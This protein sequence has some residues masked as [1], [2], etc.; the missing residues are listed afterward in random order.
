MNRRGTV[1]RQH[2]RVALRAPG[3]GGVAVVGVLHIGLPVDVPRRNLAPAWQ[4][5][6][7]VRIAEEAHLDHLIST[8]VQGGLSLSAAVRVFRDSS[9]W[10]I[11]TRR[12]GKL[13]S[14]RSPLYRRLR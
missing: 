11:C 2:V 4:R 10:G 3:G 14:A 9:T 5:V 7:A 6:E 13:C 8:R 1:A 12:A